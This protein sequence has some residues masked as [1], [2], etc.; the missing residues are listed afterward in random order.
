MIHSDY[1]KLSFSVQE[2]L[3]LLSIGR[4]TLYSLVKAGDLR[5]VKCGRKTLFR[6][7]DIQTFLENLENVE[8]SR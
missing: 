8:V 3:K 5:A 7:S 4:T 2:T 6:A 1:V